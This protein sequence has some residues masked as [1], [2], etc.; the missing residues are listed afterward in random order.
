M[1]TGE[2]GTLDLYESSNR[3]SKGVA[4]FTAGKYEDLNKGVYDFSI[5]GGV[6]GA[7]HRHAPGDPEEERADD[8]R[9]PTRTPA[10]RPWPRSTRPRT[11]PTR[12]RP[13]LRF[14]NT[15]SNDSG[16]IDA[17]LVAN[18]ASCADLSTATAVATAVSDLQASFIDINPSD[19]ATP[20][21]LC[22]TAADDRTDV[23]LDTDARRRRP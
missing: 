22:V 2:F 4:P 16:A 21:R 13:K 23:R 11:S 7:T 19:A 12:A 9:R 15:A 20:Y 1:P 14:F 5:R 10:R 6:A 3:L 17:Y 18:S 8:A